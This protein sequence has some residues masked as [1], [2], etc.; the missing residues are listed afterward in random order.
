MSISAASFV[1]LKVKTSRE[2]Y[3]IHFNIMVFPMATGGGI[4]HVIK[5]SARQETTGA[6]Q[7]CRKSSG[8]DL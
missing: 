7:G 3:V 2:L 6:T 1:T 8:S 4:N 5:P